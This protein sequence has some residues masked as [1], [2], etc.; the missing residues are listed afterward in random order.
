MVHTR[1]GDVRRS[2]FRLM[3]VRQSLLGRISTR[4][5]YSRDRGSEI[6]DMLV[7]APAMVAIGIANQPLSRQSSYGGAGA[8]DE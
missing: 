2:R 8:N 6:D 5:I 4:G 3:M 1:P 7:G